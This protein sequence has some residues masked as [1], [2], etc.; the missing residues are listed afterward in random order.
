VRGFDYQAIGEQNETGGVIG[1]RYLSVVSAEYEHYFWANWGVAAFVD[2]G[3][4]FNSDYNANIGAGLGL[5]WKS[6]VGLVR[7]DLGVPVVTDLDE[8]G[9]RVHIMI[10]PDL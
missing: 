4:A 7:V 10:G 6:P 2:A 3:D 9:V 1:G 8:T 5:R